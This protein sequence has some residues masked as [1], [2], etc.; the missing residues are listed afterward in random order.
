[1]AY[2][3]IAIFVLIMHLTYRQTSS[4]SSKKQIW[5]LT[6][7]V[8]LFF[9][10]LRSYYVGNDTIGYINRF[11]VLRNYSY[12]DIASFDYRDIGYFYFVKTIGLFTSS[13]TIFLF[14]TSFVSLI[15]VF[16]TAHRYS[17]YPILV[18]FFFITLG[19]FLFVFTGI[20]QAIA[21]S[22]CL[23][24]LPYI[25]KR[26]VVP[27]V[28]IVLLASGIHH[29]AIIF[30][31]TYFLS[32]RKINSNNLILTVVVTVIAYFF[33]DNLLQVAND[34]VGYSYG[35]EEVGNGLIFYLIL[36]IILVHAYFNRE[37]WITED[38][39]LIAMNMAII[40]AVL[41]TFRLISRTAERPSLYWLNMIP[42]VLTN[43][44]CAPRWETQSKNVMLIKLAI[45]VLALLF[46]FRRV[47]G[48]PYSFI[49]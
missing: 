11:F 24:S 48:M 34:I 25:E 16:V 37:Y 41:W 10:G 17:E 40:C 2:L 43:S 1:M 8:I 31:P 3:G 29:S 27:F 9:V 46:F 26:K 23:L 4:V 13:P 36:L 42:V 45:I 47:S 6:C 19:N 33:Y 22:I 5:I 14:I 20:R 30:L 28:L 49:V 32:Q 44:V 15:G 35:V 38:K 12:A 39:H 21:M 18:L 7:G